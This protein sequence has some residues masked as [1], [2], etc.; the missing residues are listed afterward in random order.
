MKRRLFF[1]GLGVT[2]L[3]LAVG[4]WTVDGLRWTLGFPARAFA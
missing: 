3:A 1:L 4:G 2:I